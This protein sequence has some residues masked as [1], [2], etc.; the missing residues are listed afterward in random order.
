MA[1]RFFLILL[2]AVSPAF[3]QD[4]PPEKPADAPAAVKDKPT[5]SPDALAAARKDYEAKVKEVADPIKADYLKKLDGMKKD[6]GAKGDTASALA[7]EREIKNLS[8]VITIVGRWKWLDD[9]IVEFQDDGTAKDRAGH[10]AKWLCL[11]KQSRKYQVT[12]SQGF[13][14]LILLSPDKSTIS[15]ASYNNNGGVGY[16]AAYRLPALAQDKTPDKPAPLP[17]AAGNKPA[18]DPAALAKARKAYDAKAK[19][20][21]DPIKA[22]YVKKLEGMK[23]DFGAKGDV[24]SALAVEREIKG[25]IPANNDTILGKWLWLDGNK[26]NAVEFRADGTASDHPGNPV[27]WLCIDKKARRYQTVWP[28]L[29]LVGVIQMSPDGF[30]LT[31]ASRNRGGGVAN[32]TALR[33]PEP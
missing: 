10:T 11:D 8:T 2:A 31:I 18:E 27:K 16:F 29:K 30:T 13:N 12:W 24:A 21:V 26:D 15:V 22:E 7:V 3:A 17:A 32:F 14:D 9:N 20:V 23:K 6:F 33:L 5:E 1:Y 25:L 4:K 28:T 19:E